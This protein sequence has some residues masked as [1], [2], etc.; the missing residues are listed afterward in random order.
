MT[1]IETWVLPPA[2]ACAGAA[3]AHQAPCHT[4]RHGAITAHLNTNA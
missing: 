1:M 4:D 3:L 2:L